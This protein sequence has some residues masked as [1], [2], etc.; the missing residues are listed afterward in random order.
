MFFRLKPRRSSAVHERPSICPVL[1]AAPAR[2]EQELQEPDVQLAQRSASSSWV[3]KRM[4]AF[5]DSAA[6]THDVSEVKASI[7]PDFRAASY[8]YGAVFWPRTFMG[9]TNIGSL[10]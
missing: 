1:L 5:P 9:T 10:A 3:M 7:F 2:N 4:A 8:T 6:L